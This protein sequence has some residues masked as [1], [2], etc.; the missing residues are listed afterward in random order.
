MTTD[1]QVNTQAQAA[2]PS[3]PQA[4]NFAVPEAYKDRGWAAKVKSQDDVF[5]LVDNQD[6]LIGKRPAGIPA[7]DAPQEEWDKFY[8]AARPE[9]P[10]KYTLPDIEGLP[11]GV[12]LT[13]SKKTAMDLMHKAGL[14][15]KQAADLWKEYIGTE[16]KSAQGQKEAQAAKQ[17]EIDAEF[18]KITKEHFGDKFDDVQKMTIEMVNEFVPESLRSAYAELSDNPK[19]LAAMAALAKGAN[20]K[21]AKVVAEYGAE[22]KLG[23][24]NQVAAQDIETVRKELASLRTSKDA[25]D[26]FSPNNKTVNARIQELSGIV[27]KHYRG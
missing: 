25:R 5:K 14:T 27:E 22:G 3:Q 13:E 21:I 15:N 26:P 16:L 18:D 9:S 7:P 8:Q 11:E 20:D 4:N 12:D 19:A 23:S 24:G 6:Q 1:Q 10:D 2:E 17:A